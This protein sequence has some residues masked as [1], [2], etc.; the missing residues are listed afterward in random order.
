MKF[1]VFDIETIQ[2][3][4]P[5][6]VCFF[7]G[8]DFKMFTGDDCVSCFIDFV[9]TKKYRGYNIYAHNGGK[10]DFLFILD[11]LRFR[12]YDFSLIF[13]G[14]RCALIKVYHQKEGKIKN[15]KSRNNLRFV[16][17]YNI[18]KF[19]LD[20]LT[21]DFDVKH[22]KT[23]FME[24]NG[25]RDYDYLYELYK[26]GDNRFYDY[27]KNDVLGLYEVLQVFFDRIKGHKGSVGITTPS[28]AMKTFKQQF[29]P[30]DKKIPFIETGLN[31]FFR[32]NAYYGGRTEIF[33]MFLDDGRYHCFDVNS[34]YPF[35]MKNNSFPFSP[36]RRIN[37]SLNVVKNFCGITEARVSVS[38]V[39][40]PVLPFK[41]EIRKGVNKLVFPVGRFSGVWDNVFL[42]K[43]LEVGYRVKPIRSWVFRDEFIFSEYVDYFYK[44]KQ[45]SNK[46]SCDYLI[47]KLF[48]NSLYGKFGQRDDSS[49]VVKITD[50]SKNKFKIIDVVDIENNIFRVETSNTS[51]FLFSPISIHVTSLAQL[52]L[53]GFF[54]KIFDKGGVV[55]YCDT[56]SVF[57][58]VSLNTSDRL[59]DVKKEYSF[60]RGYFVLPKMYCVV[61]GDKNKVKVKGFSK[62]LLKN[63]SEDS[64]RKA[65]FKSDFSDF[66]VV[67]DD[68]KLNSLRSSF[69]RHKCFVSCDYVK[70]S[71]KTVYDK[72]LVLP[73]FST[74][75]IV[76]E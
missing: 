64:F 69:V 6:S 40:I 24:N 63:I 4:K 37:P 34:L 11:V 57:T 73:D 44:Q 2:W 25:K 32:R 19:S 47:S 68:K 59:G 45:K 55:A 75:P 56:D 72:R 3:V 49:M 35:V 70:R 12:D 65:L 76:I 9:I 54:E 67:S 48:L 38:D 20:K 58:D 39:D 74:K 52:V 41:K 31:R 50:F 10:F 42:K 71:I 61:L 18:L 26:K 1:A 22:K 8:K 51:D 17:S 30:G 13:Q 27:V 29:L 62:D 23:N 43:A 5:Y 16:D 33:K 15:R 36:P 46:G 53:Y 14:S 28:T 66:D 7:D 21:K 60:R